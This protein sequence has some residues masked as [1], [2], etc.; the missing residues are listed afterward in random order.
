M[1]PGS[2]SR[3]IAPGKQTVGDRDM[4][5]KLMVRTDLVCASFLL[6]PCWLWQLRGLR[7]CVDIQTFRTFSGSTSPLFERT[8]GCVARAWT[9][10]M[11]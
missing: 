8:T 5:S 3:V 4:K 10:P 11:T 1:V 2:G 9:D 6:R 7:A